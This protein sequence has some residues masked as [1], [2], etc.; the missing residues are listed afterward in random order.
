[1]RLLLEPHAARAAEFATEPQLD[2]L[3]TVVEEMRS[4]PVTGELYAVY[5]RFALLD[6]EFHE[7]LA[8]ASDRPLLADAVARLHAHLHMFRLNSTPGAGRSTV[9]EHERILR[10]VLRRN[11][12]RA[13]EAMAEHL[14][15]SQARHRAALRAGAGSGAQPG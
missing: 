13:A 15:S 12:D 11:P 8:A 1:M 5:R 10:A 6:Q 4:H 7:A 14:H 2:R 3:E 9:A